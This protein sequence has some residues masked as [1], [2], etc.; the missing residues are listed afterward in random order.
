VER[1]ALLY[2]GKAKNM[3][4]TDNPEE[5]W[6]EYKDQATALNGKK[7]VAI[8]GKGTL[9]RQISSLLFTEINAQGMPTHFIKTLNETAM[10]V[11][12]CDMIPLEAV[13][14]NFASGSFERKFQVEHLKPLKPAVHE[15]YY[16]SDP[17]DDPFINDEQIIA[18]GYADKDTL[19][20]IHK[21]ADQVNAYLFQRFAGIGIK[22]VDFKLE[23]GRLADGQMVLADELSP[24]NFRLVD[25]ETGASLDKDVFRKGE[26]PLAPVYAGVLKRLQAGD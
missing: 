8:A 23:F 26:G 21:F 24:D 22:L 11:K 25:A 16:K 2:E 14:R 12:K 20:A 1:G 3:Y 7:K 6:A 19:V 9:G 13:V 17:L 10:L 4:A 5:L 15:F 18:L